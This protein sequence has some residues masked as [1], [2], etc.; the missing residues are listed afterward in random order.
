LDV[1]I[2]Q[3]LPRQYADYEGDEKMPI[4]IMEMMRKKEAESMR[5]LLRTTSLRN[6]MEVKGEKTTTT[7]WNPSML[8]LLM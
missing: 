2:D 4:A 1:L 3:K 7:I 6:L 5:A 8:M